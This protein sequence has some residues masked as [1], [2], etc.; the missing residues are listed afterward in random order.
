MIEY[1]HECE[2]QE[3]NNQDT[4]MCNDCHGNQY[5]AIC[6]VCEGINDL[7]ECEY[8]YH[9]KLIK[10]EFG[11]YEGEKLIKS[12]PLPESMNIDKEENLYPCEYPI[13]NQCSDKI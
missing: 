10:D 6:P 5:Y 12:I 9:A 8:K 13:C 4:E 2:I 11:V 7:S 1:C 3:I